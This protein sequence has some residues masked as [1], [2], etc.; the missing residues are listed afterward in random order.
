MRTKIQNLRPLIFTS[1][2]IGEDR[3]AVGTK[4]NQLTVWDIHQNDL[5]QIELPYTT[6]IYD[7]GCGIH[8]MDFCELGTNG[9]FICGGDS[10]N[11]IA[12]FETNSFQPIGLLQGHSDWMFGCKFVSENMIVSGGKDGN[13]Y[14]WKCDKFSQRAQNG[15]SQKNSQQRSF[16]VINPFGGIFSDNGKIRC[17]SVEKT[18]KIC[19][20]LNTNGTVG[21]WDAESM[22]H[23]QNEVL[24]DYS[25]LNTMD[26]K[27]QDNLIAVGSKGYTS[28]IDP[29]SDNEAL[30]IAHVDIKWGV[31]S[32]LFLDNFLVIGGGS[33]VVSFVD[34]RNP[35]QFNHIIYHKC[36]GVVRNGDVLVNENEIPQAVYTISHN[37]SKTS[38]FVG[39]GPL[40]VGASG[41]FGSV[42]N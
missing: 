25:E 29:R 15:I 37:K 16:T 24:N 10:P 41:Y 12:L 36:N 40:F 1:C 2:W 6:V 19:M 21:L 18:R 20:S 9:L 38:L 8:D 14:F 3:I 22:R 35:I 7:R 26:V 27:Q 34:M 5:R 4:D 42:W 23:I 39:G 30:C 17:V 31:R 33:G 11:D 13:I 28:L 32:V